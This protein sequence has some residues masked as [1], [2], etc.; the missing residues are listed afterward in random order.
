MMQ[1]SVLLYV[2]MLSFRVRIGVG[3]SF[4]KKIQVKMESE[5]DDPS[6]DGLSLLECLRDM[7]S[8]VW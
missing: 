8:E 5:L 2:A 3:I 7:L 4:D 6:S 1:P